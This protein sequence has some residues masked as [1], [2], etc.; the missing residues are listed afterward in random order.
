MSLGVVRAGTLS[1]PVVELENAGSITWHS[2]GP[3]SIS[4]SYHWLD[5][6][7]NPILWDGLRTPLPQPVAPGE[8]ARLTLSVRAPL[9]PGRYRLALDLLDEHRL[10]FAEIGNM[11]RELDVDVA[12]RIEERTLAVHLS[13]GP[14][15]L[16]DE[17]RRALAGQ[18]EPLAE[19][20]ASAAAVAHLVPGCVPAADWSRRILDAHAEGYAAV[21]GSVEA[22]TALF[23]RRGAASLA[24][25]ASG[26][27]RN[28]AFAWP[29]LCP[30]LVR[31]LEP[32]WEPAVEGLPAL[33]PPADEPW[34]YDGRIALTARLR[35]GRPRA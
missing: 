26:G 27:G 4:A 35:S 29:L 21:G 15:A 34:L 30:S 8:R 16:T 1:H 18:V 17:T 33:R 9:P 31:G 13:P 11:P 22:A 28:P 3:S 5:R 32:A 24:P 6:L 19:S 14:R 12:V 7:G 23:R 25:W 2:V 20:H 10:W